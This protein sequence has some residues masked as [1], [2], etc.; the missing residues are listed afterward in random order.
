[1]KNALQNDIGSAMLFI[2]PSIF[3][4]LCIVAALWQLSIVTIQVTRVHTAMQQISLMAIS[5]NS[6]ESYQSKREGYSGVFDRD[7][8]G[9]W[10]DTA[11][12]I[13]AG[14]YLCE[15]LNL[16]PEDE[17]YVSYA[18]NGTTSYFLSDVFL[19]I[20]NTSP[21]DST[22]R[23]TATLFAD[24]HIAVQLPIIEQQYITVSLKTTAQNKP[25]F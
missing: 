13:D 14:T 17:Q 1:M 16:Q 7:S 6:A 12:T 20:D 2:L 9:N 19:Q 24:L 23:L 5:E 8:S 4:T 11:I 10:Q 18:T 25:K 3:A 15:S 22:D 21:L